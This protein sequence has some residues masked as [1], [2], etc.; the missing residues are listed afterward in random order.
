MVGRSRRSLA[1]TLKLRYRCPKCKRW[2]A[3]HWTDREDASG[4]AFGSIE[5]VAYL[6]AIVAACLGYAV[7]AWELI[8]SVGVI[9][10]VVAWF[11]YRGYLRKGRR[12]YCASCDKV[13]RADFLRERANA[14]QITEIA[15]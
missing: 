2:L 11:I 15:S 3:H 10:P 12:Y 8:I 14:P 13:W 5:P 7:D 6:A 1:G 9:G 4:L